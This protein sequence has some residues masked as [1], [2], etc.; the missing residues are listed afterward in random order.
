MMKVMKMKKN[1]KK[2]IWKSVGFF[3]ATTIILF[4]ILYFFMNPIIQDAYL[5]GY[6][7]GKAEK[8]ELLLSITEN[9]TFEQIGS[10]IVQNINYS[11]T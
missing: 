8:C 9:Q 3:F 6:E 2:T 5:K 11:S 1:I 4:L 7:R 10:N